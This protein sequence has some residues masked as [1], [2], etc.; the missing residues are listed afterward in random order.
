MLSGLFLLPLQDI[1]LHITIHMVLSVYRCPRTAM[2]SVWAPLFFRPVQNKAACRFVLI[3]SIY[4]QFF[5]ESI[6]N[7]SISNQGGQWTEKRSAP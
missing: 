2:A 7:S 6:T 3:V 4:L 5:I 1:S